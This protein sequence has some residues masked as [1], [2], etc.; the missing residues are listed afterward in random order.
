MGLTRVSAAW[1]VLWCRG[2]ALA[3]VGGE[4]RGRSR[5]EIVGGICGE[6]RVVPHGMRDE[7]DIES[8]QGVGLARVRAPDVGDL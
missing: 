5:G 6:A 2:G 1:S 7:L 8:D 3:I 4:G